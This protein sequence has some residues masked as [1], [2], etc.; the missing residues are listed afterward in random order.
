MDLTVKTDSGTGPLG[1][2]SSYATWEGDFGA[3]IVS[4][5]RGGDGEG[6]VETDVSY[7]VDSDGVGELA[8]EE[9]R[10]RSLSSSSCDRGGRRWSLAEAMFGAGGGGGEEDGGWRGDPE[11]ESD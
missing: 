5:W 1:V 9:L 6:D 3:A 10:S 4:L 8:A 11:G 2:S 7:P